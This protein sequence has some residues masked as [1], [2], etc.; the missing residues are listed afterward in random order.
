MYPSVEQ[1]VRLP[2]DQ[3]QR[4]IEAAR[5]YP[6]LGPVG[7]YSLGLAG[8]PLA[9]K[10]AVG[11][12]GL[13]LDLAN[14]QYTNVGGV[15]GQTGGVMFPH[16]PQKVPIA[17]VYSHVTLVADDDVTVVTEPTNAPWHSEACFPT[18]FPIVGVTKMTFT[19]GGSRPY[20][21]FM[22]FSSFGQPLLLAPLG[23]HQERWASPTVLKA[24]AAATADAFTAIKFGSSDGPNQPDPEKQGQPSLH[25]GPVGQKVFIIDNSMSS[26]D[27]LNVNIRGLIVSGKTYANDPVT[28]ASL[29][30]AA[31]DIGRFVLNTKYHILQVRLRADAAVALG[32][33]WGPTVQY[34][35]YSYL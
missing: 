8:F 4:L 26:A 29:S 34:L 16:L 7:K 27:V 5:P 33:T 10:L 11:G 22:I 2:E 25:T 1:L 18:M 12:S 30:L 21:I 20:N 6:T 19:A 13:I 31:G 3:L 32:T 28:G 17:D 24:A 23:Y 14:N 35:G 9:D 15:P